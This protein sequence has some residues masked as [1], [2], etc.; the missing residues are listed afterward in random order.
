M[1]QDKFNLT[2]PYKN[3]ISLFTNVNI[4]HVDLLSNENFSGTDIKNLYTLDIGFKAKLNLKKNWNSE[5]IFKP[6]ITNNEIR[7]IE[8][9]NFILNTS[10]NF[11][12]RIN[13]KSEIKFGI[14]YGTLFGKNSFNPTF[15]YKK[16]INDALSFSIGF[17]KSSLLYELNNKNQF[18]LDMIYNNQF[19]TT[20]KAFSRFSN[21]TVINYESLSISGLDLSL[22][23]KYIYFNDSALSFTFGKSFFNEFKIKEN[24]NEV[25]NFNF[26]NNFFISIGFKYNLNFK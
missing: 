22:N 18:Q 19:Y 20:S 4:S 17:P 24:N 7:N 3:S 12:K 21:H 6:Q 25:T 16:D 15:E 11:F 9:N 26:K 23:Y 10:L 14:E 2:I 5:F 13:Q 1:N 8:F